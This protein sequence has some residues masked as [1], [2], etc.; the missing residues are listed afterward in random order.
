LAEKFNPENFGVDFHVGGFIAMKI[1]DHYLDY[2]MMKNTVEQC[3][4]T[5][6][7]WNRKNAVL[8]RQ[9]MKHSKLTP[10]QRSSWIQS[11]D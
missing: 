9:V 1:R 8:T 11:G 4:N 6:E 2:K 7:A 5:E 3:E 10:S